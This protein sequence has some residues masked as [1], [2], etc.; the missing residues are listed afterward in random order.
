MYHQIKHSKILRSAHTEYLC[1]LC[2][3]SVG[4]EVAEWLDLKEH[5]ALKG[6]KLY[7]NRDSVDPNVCSGM[8]GLSETS[9][10]F[11]VTVCFDANLPIA[12]NITTL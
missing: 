4:K 5:E 12:L 1:V 9:L 6:R 7:R 2:D 8:S 3:G 10:H 11:I